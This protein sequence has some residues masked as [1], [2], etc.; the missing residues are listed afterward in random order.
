MNEKEVGWRTCITVN[1]ASSTVTLAVKPTEKSFGFDYV[2]EGHT[3]QEEIFQAVGLPVTQKCLQGYN[4]TILCYGQTGTGKSHTVFGTPS[5]DTRSL[6]PDRGLVP[7]V[8][9]FLWGHI[10]EVEAQTAGAISFR[11]YCSFYEI[12]NECVYDLLDMT[13]HSREA[14]GQGTNMG[15]Q[16]RE[17]SKRGVFVEGMTEETV[18]SPG[19]AGRVLAKGYLNRSRRSLFIAIPIPAGIPQST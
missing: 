3:S 14:P 12:Y 5:T 11:C 2:A 16:V 17:D 9:E 15:L 19:D 18:S 4:G 13:A 1:T 10:A 7:R 6:H 8:L